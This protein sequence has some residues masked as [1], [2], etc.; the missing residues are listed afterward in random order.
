[1]AQRGG[2]I[3]RNKDTVVRILMDE[4]MVPWEAEAEWASVGRIAIL[5]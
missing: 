3:V 5:L 2:A 4:V 1:M